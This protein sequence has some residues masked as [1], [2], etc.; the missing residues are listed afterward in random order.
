MMV[1]IRASA[2]A[3]GYPA[4]GERLG[5]VLCQMLLETSEGTSGFAPSPLLQPR[6]G[7]SLEQGRRFRQIKTSE[8]WL[9]IRQREDGRTKV[10]TTEGRQLL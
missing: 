3:P 5:N 7:P 6:N 2:G 8:I 4:N 9:K 1:L 10:K